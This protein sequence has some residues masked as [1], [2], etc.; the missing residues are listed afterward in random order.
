MLGYPELK[1]AFE[2]LNL[3]DKPVI[4]HTSLKKFGAIR[5]GAETVLS[6][7]LETMGGL[8]VPA[9]TYMTMVTPEVGPPN[10]GITYGSD[11][12][13]NKRAEPFRLD[14]PPDKMMG[15]FPRAVIQYQDAR[16][17]AHPI[18]SFGGVGMDPVLITQNSL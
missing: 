10:N 13:N 6:A 5:G 8:I 7:V 16:R 3:F 18:L 17:T 12:D 14:M 1:S 4:A 11:R 2:E 9:F 15:I